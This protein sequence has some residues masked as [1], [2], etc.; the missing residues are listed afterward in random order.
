MIFI[1]DMMWKGDTLKSIL[2]FPSVA[3]AL[4]KLLQGCEAGTAMPPLRANTR[5]GKLR[6][7]PSSRRWDLTAHTPDELPANVFG[8]KEAEQSEQPGS[9]LFLLSV[10]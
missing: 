7:G 6:A 1:T 5:E 2:V 9:C 3:P 4:T 10:L 8:W